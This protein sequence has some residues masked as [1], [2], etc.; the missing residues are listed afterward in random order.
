MFD[1]LLCCRSKDHDTTPAYTKSISSSSFPDIQ[2]AVE[3]VTPQYDSPLPKSRQRQIVSVI[4]GRKAPPPPNPAPFIN[5]PLPLSPAMTHQSGPVLS[6]ASSLTSSSSLTRRSPSTASH[7]PLKGHSPH[8][9][10]ASSA[11][12]FIPPTRTTSLFITSGSVTSAAASTVSSNRTSRSTTR[13]TTRI[14]APASPVTSS[15]SLDLPDATDPTQPLAEGFQPSMETL[16]SF[17]RR[18]RSFATLGYRVDDV[19]PLPDGQRPVVRSGSDG[20][21]RLN[22]AASRR[23]RREAIAVLEPRREKPSQSTS[24][25]LTSAPHSR[26]SS[27]SSTDHVLQAEI[28]TLQKEVGRLRNLLAQATIMESPKNSPV[29]SAYL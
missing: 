4:T 28:V 27:V 16:R 3:S 12:T 13:S 24:P 2:E 22:S 20:V 1:F 8:A 6:G 26:K 11:V 25:Q 17:S 9:S 18:R 15:L 23:E 21:M 29:L 7:T 5:R 10:F 19:P 14:R